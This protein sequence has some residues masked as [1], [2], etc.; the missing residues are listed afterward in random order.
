[1]IYD[2]KENSQLPDV[3]VY[4]GG[5]STK[6]TVIYDKFSKSSRRM[7]P[8]FEVLRDL[9]PVTGSKRR[10]VD[11]T[12]RPGCIYALSSGMMTEKTV[13]NGFARN[14]I[15]NPKNSLLFVGYTDS[16]TPGARIKNAERGET[17]SLDDEL[18]PV[19]LDCEVEAFN[20]SGHAPRNQ[21]LDFA[22]ETNAQRTFLVHGDPPA[23]DWFLDKVEG[24]EIPKSGKQIFL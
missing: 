11:L 2:G 5:L 8:G 14:F 17:V 6:M 19:L 23:L 13:S 12:Y 21:L 9:E 3:P 4:I 7:K 22:K 20:F 16:S 1:M 24:A 18:S 10:R 15:N